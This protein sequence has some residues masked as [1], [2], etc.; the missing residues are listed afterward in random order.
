MSSGDL[1]FIERRRHLSSEKAPASRNVRSRRGAP[2]IHGRHFFPTFRTILTRVLRLC[3]EMP[4]VNN[5][6][7]Q[8]TAFNWQRRD[9]RRAKNRE[10]P[11]HSNS[12]S[13]SFRCSASCQTNKVLKSVSSWRVVA[14][15]KNIIIYIYIQGGLGGHV[16]FLHPNYDY[17]ENWMYH[18]LVKLAY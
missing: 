8:S 3:I 18:P 5:E 4:L 6:L 17:Y 11:S 2:R 1:W 16:G 12:L 10:P 14:N 7:R 9:S 15:Y 13:H